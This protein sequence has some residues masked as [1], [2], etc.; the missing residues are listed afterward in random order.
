MKYLLV[1]ALLLSQISAASEQQINFDFDGFNSKGVLTVPNNGNLD[2]VVVLVHGSGPWDMN[3]SMMNPMTRQI[4]STLFKDIANHLA[5]QGIASIRYNKRHV[6][7]A[8]NIDQQKFMQEGNVTNFSSDLS[9]VVSWIK[10]NEQLNK[11]SLYL[12]GWS[13]GALTSTLVAKK[14]SIDGLILHGAPVFLQETFE[15]QRANVLRPWLTEKGFEQL[16]VKDVFNLA[17]SGNLQSIWLGYSIDMS[18]GYSNAAFHSYLDTNSDGKLH[19]DNEW[20]PIYKAYA[21]QTPSTMKGLENDIE[22]LK[23]QPLLVLQGSLD[24]NTPQEFTDKLIAKLSQHVSYHKFDGLGHSLGKVT[25]RAEDLFPP[26]EKA[27]LNTLTN[28]LKA[29]SK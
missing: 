13:E 9:T 27:P 2:T 5:K 8:G 19:L 22:T 18:K 6:H 26:I 14:H 25:H 28:W 7:S 12:Y 15:F 16:S 21:Q 4:S 29:Q 24:G 3:A 17:G 20:L 11:A 1:L 23:K 10:H